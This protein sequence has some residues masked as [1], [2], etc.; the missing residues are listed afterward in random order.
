MMLRMNI[1]PHKLTA[2]CLL[3]LLLVSCAQVPKESVELSATVGRDLATVHQSHREMAKV[4]FGRMRH[5]INRFVDDVYAPFQIQHAMARQNQL[6]RSADPEDRSRSLLL[7][8]NAAFAPDASP[9]LQDA[10]LAGMTSMVRAIREDVESMRNELLDPLDA[11]EAEVLGSIDRAYQQIHYANSIVTG[12]LSSVVEVHETQAELMQAIGVERDLRITVGDNLAR[13]STTIGDLVQAA[14]NAGTQF[15][16]VE[17]SVQKLR[18]AVV[19]LEQNLRNPGE[20]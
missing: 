8:I 6:A 5:D 10:V 2:A 4:L 18:E 19:E 16:D 11:Q 14:E 20:E 12:H 9:E 1:V 17:E 13:T 3:G 15:Q 7:A